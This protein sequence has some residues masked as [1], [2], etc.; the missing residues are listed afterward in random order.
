MNRT[1]YIVIPLNNFSGILFGCKLLS[2]SLEK[3]EIIIKQFNSLTLTQR[4]DIASESSRREARLKSE[5]ETN[6]EDMYLTC[7]MVDLNI[8][9]T[10][11]NID[12]ATVCLCLKPPCSG[13]QKIIV[14]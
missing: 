8:I 9:A 10:K 12:P 13:S 3:A 2:N 5:L 7:V 4:A 1:K 6:N 11:Y 14:K